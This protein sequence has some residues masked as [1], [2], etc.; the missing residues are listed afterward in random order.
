[1]M[2][3][4]PTLCISPSGY[5]GG[6]AIVHLSHCWFRISRLCCLEIPFPDDPVVFIFCSIFSDYFDSRWRWYRP[7]I[8]KSMMIV[9]WYDLDGAFSLMVEAWFSHSTEEG[10]T[11][12]FNIPMMMGEE[13]ITWAHSVTWLIHYWWLW[14]LDTVFID[15]VGSCI[16]DSIDTF[17]TR[18]LMIL[19]TFCAILILC[20]SLSILLTAHSIDDQCSPSLIDSIWWFDGAVH[21]NSTDLILPFS[22]SPS[23]H[24]MMFL[25]A[26][27]T[28]RPHH[29][30]LPLPTFIHLWCILFIALP[31]PSGYTYTI[32]CPFWTHSLN[33]KAVGNP[34]CDL[35]VTFT[36]C[37]IY[38][39]SHCRWY[40]EHS[41][42]L[43]F[44]PLPFL[45][46]FIT[47]IVPT[48]RAN[49]IVSPVDY[50]FVH[51]WFLI[52]SMPFGDS[53]FRYVSF[54]GS[55]TLHS[56]ALC[57]YCY[58]LFSV[59]LCSL[60]YICLWRDALTLL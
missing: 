3:G 47:F 24:S 15:V 16:D 32:W 9:V 60:W 45:L 35:I 37:P 10:S 56:V 29:S 25:H 43:L 59:A 46:P 4:P 49:S 20:G 55:I 39:T 50:I 42:H 5:T 31:G 54:L 41:F 53:L 22:N 18:Y 52:I 51:S 38:H 28:F 26:I 27:I 58:V 21:S 1:M 48:S 7:T 12:T 17:P 40:L 34:C 36:D 6:P 13:W 23:L 44:S 8:T 11:S 14:W 57:T 2:S 33:F 30:L 19:T